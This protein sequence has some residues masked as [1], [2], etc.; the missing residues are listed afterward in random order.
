MGVKAKSD[1]ETYW[2]WWALFHQSVMSFGAY[3][4]YDN[5]QALQSKLQVPPSNLSNFQY[6]MLYSLYEFPNIILP[7]FGGLIIDFFGVRITTVVFSLMVILAQ[8]VFTLGVYE[9]SFFLMALGRFIFALGGENLSVAHSVLVTKWFRS[10]E[11]AFALGISLSVIRLGSMTNSLTTPKIAEAEGNIWYPCLV[12]LYVCIISLISAIWACW[13]DYKADR[14][15]RR[16]EPLLEEYTD[17]GQA[18]TEGG[19]GHGHDGKIQLS[20]LKDLGKVFWILTVNSFLAYAVIYTFLGASNDILVKCFGFDDKVSGNLVSIIYIMSA[21][22]SPFFALIIDRFGMRVFWLN[23]AT[24]LFIATH[25][26]FVLLPEY[27]EES[28]MALLPVVGFGLGYAVYTAVIWPCVP[29]VVSEKVCGT[30]YGLATAF[31]NGMAALVFMT[32]GHIQDETTLKSGYFWSEML[33]L[34][35][36]VLAFVSGIH[37]N[38]LDKRSGRILANPI[39]QLDEEPDDDDYEP[40]M[41]VKSMS[42]YTSLQPIMSK[43]TDNDGLLLQNRTSMSFG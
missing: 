11:L 22:I 19:G 27:E 9:N 41:K 23:L 7:L 30:A 26:L 37:L 32:A 14:D 24:V 21:V 18:E 43:I 6:S 20:D 40:V 3:Y 1:K 29:M 35:F 12:G 15:E 39:A 42:A 8:G 25:C 38:R 17:V 28:Y 36:S 2:R 5:P 10:K 13:L 34:L 16:V 4:C 31:Q 33:L